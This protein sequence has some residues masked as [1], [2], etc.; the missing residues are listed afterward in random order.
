LWWYA[1]NNS[2]QAYDTLENGY[3]AVFAHE[4]FHLVQ[5]NVL[6]SA[7][8]STHK[9]RNVFIEAQGKFV[10]SVQ[11]PELE[12]FREHVVSLNSEYVAAANRFLTH[13]LNSSYRTLEAAEIDKYDAALYWRFLY[14]Q[15]GG[16]MGIIRAALEE[17]ACQY[18]PDI[19][20]SLGQVMDTA[21]ARA[22]GPFQT[23]EESL[24]AFSQANYA[25]RLGHGRCTT[26]DRAGCGN[27]Y[28]DPHYVY[29]T[30][31]L[32]ATVDYGG[33]RLVHEGA[34]PASFGMDFIEVNLRDLHDQPI[35]LVIQSQGARFSVQ[36][37][38]LRGAG[39]N[40]EDITQVWTEQ[41]GGTKPYAL[42]PQP[43]FTLRSKGDLDAEVVLRRDTAQCD[44]VALI[45]TRLDADEGLD[46]AGDYVITLDAAAEPGDGS[47]GL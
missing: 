46:A 41:S 35:R 25:L 32:E 19:E 23:F 26:A 4:F 30:P 40:P 33:S 16:D 27:K 38:A 3:K 13:R 1:G 42:T 11:H 15:A 44:R 31:P 37:W 18:H 8:C 34:I 39:A 2:L 9:W 10:P 24:I 7:G 12:L 17:M 47:V 36:V 21:L 20:R 22:D 29:V 28:D 14:E 45:V 43:A 6:L 5:W